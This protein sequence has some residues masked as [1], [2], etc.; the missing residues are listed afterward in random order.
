MNYLENELT[1]KTDHM[2]AVANYLRRQIIVPAPNSVGAKSDGAKRFQ[3]PMVL[4][5]KRQRQ[6]VGAP[7]RQR[8]NDGAKTA[9]P[10]SSI[11]LEIPLKTYCYDT[12]IGGLLKYP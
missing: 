3:R 12:K 4:A 8:Q 5:P 9:A 2:K 6:M 10:N 1:V 11:P 7:N